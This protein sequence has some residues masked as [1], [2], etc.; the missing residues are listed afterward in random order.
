MKV[1]YLNTIQIE[2]ERKA[3][4]LFEKLKQRDIKKAQQM[5]MQG[6]LI[7]KRMNKRPMKKRT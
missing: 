7:N 4:E 5:V 2:A 3:D 1:V 6:W